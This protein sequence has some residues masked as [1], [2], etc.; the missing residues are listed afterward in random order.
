MDRILSK[1][2]SPK[3]IQ[4]F[5]NKAPK[6]IHCLDGALFAALALWYHGEKPLLMDLASTPYD[7][8]HV[9][10]LFRKYGRWGA[11][12]KTHHAVLRYREPVYA[13]V[14]ELAMSYFHEYFLDD[15][16]KTLRSYSDPVDLSKLKDP[17]WITAKKN[18]GNLVDL[19]NAAPH[20]NILDR[21]MIAGLRKADPIERKAGKLKEWTR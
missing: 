14:R 18:L 10:A 7:Y 20:H 21:R 4:D 12:S 2:S 17:T 19:L 13:S 16:V 15:G 9:V 11:I 3:K 5:L 8:D 6:S 1:L